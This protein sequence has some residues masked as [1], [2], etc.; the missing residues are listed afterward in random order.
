MLY[1]LEKDGKLHALIEWFFDYPLEGSRHPIG[2]VF[3]DNGLYA[4]EAL[5]F[6]RDEAQSSDA[7]RRRERR[8][9]SAGIW[10]ARTARP[11]GSSRGGRSRRFAARSNR[12]GRRRSRA[13]FRRPDLVELVALDPTIKL[14]IRYATT[15]N[16]LGVPLYTS[17][18]A[19]MER[20]AAEALVRAHRALGRQGYGLLIHDAYRPWQRDQVVL[21]GHARRGTH[22]SWPTRRR[23]RST[24]GARPST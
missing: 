21:G 17:A 24:T 4:G 10:T 15:N 14:D 12:L 7:G 6:T 11:F 1:I 22:V 2:F 13:T 3:P 8:S 18:R 20:P 23:A 5:I 9:S 16:F 19:F